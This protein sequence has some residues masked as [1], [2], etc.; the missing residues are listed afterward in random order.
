MTKSVTL[1]NFVTRGS[2]IMSR[3]TSLP[4]D[5]PLNGENFGLPGPKAL[6]K[7]RKRLKRRLRRGQTTPKMTVGLRER[8]VALMKAQG[9]TNRDIATALGVSNHTVGRDLV[10]PQVQASLQE[11]RGVIKDTILRCAAQSDLIEQAFE[12]A[13]AKVKAGEAK[14]FDAAMRG[15]NALEKTTQS[16]SGEALKVDAQ[17]AAVIL[18]RQEI[19]SRI[20]HILAST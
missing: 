16:A 9:E 2:V 4:P 17:V 7:A 3:M 14:E 13:R 1:T 19:Y 18:N 5:V 12:M 20:E 10:K 15:L 11:L 8:Q 6:E